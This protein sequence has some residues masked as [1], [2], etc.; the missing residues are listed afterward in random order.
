MQH[1]DQSPHLAAFGNNIR[2]L[3]QRR[4]ETDPAFSLRQ[5]ASRCGVTAAYLSRVERGEVA[6]P[7]E[8]TLIKLAHE[9]GEDTDLILAMAGKVSADLR[10]TILARPQLFAE[11]IRSIKTMPDKAVLRIVRDVH[12]GNW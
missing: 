8:E 1:I 2:K 5:V 9:L 12:D 6:P 7:G 3:R 4:A 11:L 10:S